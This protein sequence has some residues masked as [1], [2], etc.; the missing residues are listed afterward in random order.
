MPVVD[1]ELIGVKNHCDEQVANV[2]LGVFIETTIKKNIE[3]QGDG[4][5]LVSD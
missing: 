5:W 4:K 1:Q 2:P 3:Q